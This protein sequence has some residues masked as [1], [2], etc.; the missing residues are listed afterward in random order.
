MKAAVVIPARDE[1][2][3]IGDCLQAVRAAVRSS[4]M[5][6][7]IFVIDDGSV[8]DTAAVAAGVLGGA[9]HVFLRN[10]A[11]VGA[12]RREGAL[13]ALADRHTPE[14]LAFTD[15]DTVVPGDWLGQLAELFEAGAD[16]VA[17]TVRLEHSADP[18]LLHAFQR[19]YRR[20]IGTF[21][22]THIHGANLAVST[23]S[24][25]AVGG[26][27]PLASGEDVDLWRRLGR[28]GFRLASPPDL[29]VTTSARLSG[30]A[31]GGV[32]GDLARLSEGIRS[33]PRNTVRAT[34]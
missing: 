15:A 5:D 32:A 3:L 16:G 21:A 22:H 14:F 17:G 9:G 12:A 18:S 13:I 30:R 8:D 10:F 26:F 7:D 11:N 29:A 28:A 1:A 23:A 31:S 2:V 24:Y 4:R 27:R 25:L 33:V 34:G 19:S 6:C 20:G